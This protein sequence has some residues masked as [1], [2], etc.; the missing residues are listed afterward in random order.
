[1]T[2]ATTDLCDEHP[3]AQVCEPIFQSFG[4]RPAFSG[5]IAT[6]KVFEDNSLV[7]ETVGL[8]GEGRVLVVDGGGSRRCS[9]FGGNLAVAAATNGWAGVVVFG[10]VRDVDELAAQPIGIRALAAFPRKS[11]RGLHSGQ[12]GVPVTFAGVVFRTGEWLSADRDGIVVLP[13]APAVS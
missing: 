2:L 9:L 7:R 12:L 11:E 6:L 3:E 5:P 10:C 4:G 1:M 8:P 13:E